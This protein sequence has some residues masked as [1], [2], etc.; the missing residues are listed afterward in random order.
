[1]KR[2]NQKINVVFLLSAVIAGGIALWGIVGN[3]SFAG[4][5]DKLM[6]GLK[7][8]F[9]WLY[10]GVMLLFVLFALVLAFSPLGKVRLGDDGEKP[11]LL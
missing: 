8:H 11:S 3:T 7:D 4:V 6:Q 2:R 10:L 9:S 1:M 5:S